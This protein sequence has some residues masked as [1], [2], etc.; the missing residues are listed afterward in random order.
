MHFDNGWNSELAV[1]N[2]QRIVEALEFDLE[3]YV[4]D[5]AEFRDLQRAF[6]LASVIDF[7]LP[8]DNAI[9]AAM[10]NAARQHGV[11]HVLMGTNVATEHGM[12]AAWT[13]LKHDWTNIKAIHALT[14]RSR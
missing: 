5:W 6:L 1:E 4:V 2:I 7:E 10:L 12:P 9:V 8:T 3:T 14:V 13:W 11:K